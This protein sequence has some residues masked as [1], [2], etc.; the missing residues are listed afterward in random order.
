MS[1]IEIS[2]PMGLGDMVRQRGILRELM[3]DRTVYLRTRNVAPFYDLIAAGLK[4]SQYLPDP[5]IT[6][7]TAPPPLEA[8]PPDTPLVKVDYGPTDIR[9]T[10]SVIAAQWA[11]AGLPAPQC[12]DFSLPIPAEWRAPKYDTGGKRLMIYRP[13]ILTH[14]WLQ[15]GR[16]P[17]PHAYDTLYRTIRDR[18]F[19]VSVC[20]LKPDWEWIVPP[21][22][23]VDATENGTLDFEGL[24]AL[25]ASADLVFGNM[26]FTPI[27]AQAVG[28]P[29]VCVFGGY[30]NSQTIAPGY[31]LSPTLSIDVDHPCDCHMFRHDCDK[32]ITL[33]PAQA[34]LL[35]FIEGLQQ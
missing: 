19:V 9:R 35:A 15:P 29:N 1:A 5:I 12:P 34:R 2:G 16:S 18:Y 23:A 30:E 3:K 7:H 31:H 10:G 24:A 14:K 6:E 13:V 8:A 25:F 20:K 11:S 22:P 26:G 4:I 28:T 32:R 21:L 17:D 33:P 27:L